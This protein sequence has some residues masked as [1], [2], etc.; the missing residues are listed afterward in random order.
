MATVGL[1]GINKFYDNGYHAIH[2]LDLSF[3][4]KEFLVLVGPSV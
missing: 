4:D 1:E 3:A 2:D